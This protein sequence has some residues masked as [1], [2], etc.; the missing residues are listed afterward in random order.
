MEASVCVILQL[1]FATRGKKKILTAYPRK[2]MMIFGVTINQTSLF[3]LP[4][5]QLFVF[6]T[7]LYLFEL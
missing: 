2:R 7:K 5:R 3:L 6:L 4:K 1:Y